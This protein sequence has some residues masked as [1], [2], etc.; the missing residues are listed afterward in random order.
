MPATII[1]LSLRRAMPHLAQAM[2]FLVLMMGAGVAQLSHAASA[3]AVAS[4][5]V[6]APL[7]VRAVSELDFGSFSPSLD[8]AGSVDVATDGRYVTKHVRL[9]GATLP[10]PARFIVQGAP[11][12]SFTVSVPASA[13]VTVNGQGKVLPIHF[14]SDHMGDGTSAQTLEAD[15]K[16]VLAVGGKLDIAA[17]QTSGVYA[18]NLTITV[19]Y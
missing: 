17:R 12:E 7:S 3:V 18:S 11:Y 5:T 2:F 4:A 6:V 10:A 1:F 19:D 15:G 16:A 13:S 14:Q 8:N 9:L